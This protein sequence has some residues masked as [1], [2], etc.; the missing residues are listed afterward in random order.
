VGICCVGSASVLGEAAIAAE[1]A[2]AGESNGDDGQG[3]KVRTQLLESPVGMM[4]R[5]GR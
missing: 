4:G 2:A 3:G 1:K 5:E